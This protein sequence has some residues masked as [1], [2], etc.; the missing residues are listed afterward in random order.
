MRLARDTQLPDHSRQGVFCTTCNEWQ[1]GEIESSLQGVP[2]PTCSLRVKLHPAPQ[3]RPCAEPRNCN[4]WLSSPNLIPG[5]SQ[6]LCP[7]GELTPFIL[8][9]ACVLLVLFRK[10]SSELQ[11][12]RTGQ[13]PDLLA[14]RSRHKEGVPKPPAPPAAFSAGPGFLTHCHALPALTHFQSELLPHQ[15]ENP[16][17]QGMCTFNQSDPAVTGERNFLCA[18]LPSEFLL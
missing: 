14:T 16:A 10:R 5:P 4:R 3:G 1:S 9:T 12:L 15:K 8:P 18:R 17:A 13:A 7:L 2:E 6:K 11:R